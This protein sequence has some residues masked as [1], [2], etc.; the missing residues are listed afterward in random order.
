MG[1]QCEEHCSNEVVP[2]RLNCGVDVDCLLGCSLEMAA[3]I[4][5]CPCFLM[6]PN[7]CLGC[8][9]SFCQCTGD[10]TE[11]PNYQ[12]CRQQLDDEYYECIVACPPQ[13]LTCI[14]Q[15]IREENEKLENCPCM[16]SFELII[17]QLVLTDN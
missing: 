5:G 16:V 3:C 8:S 13:D 11:D 4:N 14:N 2:C 1:L 7:G 6:C 17:N 12:I 10:P 9:S 15:C